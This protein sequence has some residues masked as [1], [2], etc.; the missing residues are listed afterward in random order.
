MQKFL[1]CGMQNE[2]RMINSRHIL[3]TAECDQNVVRIF[4]FALCTIHR[5]L[6]RIWKR[7]RHHHRKKNC[8]KI[9]ILT[10]FWSHSAYCRMCRELIILHSFCIPQNKNFCIYSATSLQKDK[11]LIRLNLGRILYSVKILIVSKLMQKESFYKI[12]NYNAEYIN[13]LIF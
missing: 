1:F 7:V 13:L 2:C 6:S 5:S 10:T 3:L 4:N 12:Q 11:F 9:K 8:A